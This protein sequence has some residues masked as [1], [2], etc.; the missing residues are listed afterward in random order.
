MLK[1]HQL[2]SNYIISGNLWWKLGNIY[3]WLTYCFHRSMELSH[4]CCRLHL[5]WLS[6]DRSECCGVLYRRCWRC[7]HS[8]YM[9]CWQFLSLH[10]CCRLVCLPKWLLQCKPSKN[11][12]SL[13]CRLFLFHYCSNPLRHRRILSS[14]RSGLQNLPRWLFLCLNDRL[15]CCM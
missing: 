13:S 7:D 14:I 8:I 11:L 4:L 6:S 2:P 1:K 3:L 10:E 12:F 9:Q 15:T 5:Y